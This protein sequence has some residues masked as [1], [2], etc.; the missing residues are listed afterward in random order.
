MKKKYRST[1]EAFQAIQQALSSI[2]V[3]GEY[4]LQVEL[5]IQDL[6]RQIGQIQ[7][8]EE[9]KHEVFYG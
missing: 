1:R 4:P 7:V 6:A 5:N 2:K 9:N 8:T 3:L